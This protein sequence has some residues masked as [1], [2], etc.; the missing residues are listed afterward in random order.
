M[1]KMTHVAPRRYVGLPARLRQNLKTLGG[2]G[3]LDD[4]G[5]KSGHCLLLTLGEDR[6]LIAA[7]GER[8]FKN[9]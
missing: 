5:G 7:I 4:C 3:A 2:V 1:P 9:G 6:S 8:F